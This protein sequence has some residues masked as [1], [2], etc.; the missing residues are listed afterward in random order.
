M[1]LRYKLLINKKLNKHDHNILQ[2][3]KNLIEYQILVYN[4]Y[5]LYKLP[6][7]IDLGKILLILDNNNTKLS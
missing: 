4:E 1:K 2:N 3:C 7:S 5:G 6:F